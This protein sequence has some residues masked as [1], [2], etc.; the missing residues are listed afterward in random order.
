MTTQ[1]L[2][3]R[4]LHS[5]MALGDLYRFLLSALHH[6]EETAQIEFRKFVSGE[7]SELILRL[8]R[9]W[10]S[11]DQLEWPKE[12]AT[13]L[14]V[15]HTGMSACYE[16][17]VECAPPLSSKVDG[18]AQI[19]QQVSA[20][21]TATAAARRRAAT[22]WRH[23]ASRAAEALPSSE[24]WLAFS[25]P[26]AHD[27]RQVEQVGRHFGGLVVTPPGIEPGGVADHAPDADHRR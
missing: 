4:L 21:P 2:A 12:A 10:V 5:D 6:D 8:A 24:S 26:P 3:D 16:R 27:V 20:Q 23:R 15:L 7:L 18:P 25:T 14:G 19:L 11:Q 1:E 17:D 22:N 13:K 9:V